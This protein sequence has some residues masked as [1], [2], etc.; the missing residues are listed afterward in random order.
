MERCSTQ[1][2]YPLFWILGVTVL[3]A[4]APLTAGTNN[5]ALNCSASVLS[6]NT[7]IG[8]NQSG[9]PPPPGLFTSVNT[10]M[11][12][13]SFVAT[14]TDPITTLSLK[15]D[16]VGAQLNS[17][18]QVD[19]EPDGTISTSSPT[20]TFPSGSSMGTATVQTT[21]STIPTQAQGAVFVP[22]TFNIATSL[23]VGQI[24]W[25]VASANYPSSGTSYIEWRAATS[26]LHNYVGD[27]FS[28]SFN[29]WQTLSNLNYDF[30]LGC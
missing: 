3:Q 21:V 18:V 28:T 24:Y 20:P 2:V 10:T 30:R 4:C 17:Q 9:A 19:I 23:T 8:I 15:L 5:T 1:W 13:Q 26:A 22:F 16:A 27:Y 29:S 6:D 7:A 12:A 11:L 14:S 25:I